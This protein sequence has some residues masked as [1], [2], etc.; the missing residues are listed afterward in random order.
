MTELTLNEE[1]EVALEG[2]IK[3]W[4]RIVA[5]KGLDKMGSNCPLC[6]VR[7][8]CDFCPVSNKSKLDDCHGTPYMKWGKHQ[9]HDHTANPY[10]CW[11]ITEGCKECEKLAKAEL[12]FLISLLPK[13]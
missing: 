2:S 1:Y 7:D 9:I 6:Q 5:G 10:R 4:E 11:K 12:D 13:K 8:N 3:K